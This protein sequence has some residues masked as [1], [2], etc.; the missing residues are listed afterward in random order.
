MSGTRD[1][2]MAIGAWQPM[3][4][5]D[6]SAAGGGPFGDVHAFRMSLWT[7][8]LKIWDPVFRFPATL[9]CTRKVKDMAAYNWQIYSSETQVGDYPVTP[10]QL[11]AYPLNV[12][13]DGSIEYL[14]TISS[15]PDF[16]SSAKIMGKTNPMIPEKLTT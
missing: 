10:G 1:T 13:N 6:E 7:Q 8:H 12:L 4:T 15:F 9:E 2:E 14:E 3:Y 11:L 5:V 16:P